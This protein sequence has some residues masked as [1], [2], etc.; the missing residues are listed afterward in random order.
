MTMRKVTA[1]RGAAWINESIA[2]LKNIGMPFWTQALIIGLLG[3]IPYISM[4]QGVLILFFYGSL[5]LCLSN[6]KGQCN[7]FSGF[8]NGNFFR[9][10]PVLLIN[11]AVAIIVMIAIWPD[12]KIAVEA[13]LQGQKLNEEQAI[14]VVLAMFKHMLW[15][16]PLLIVLHWVSLLA[17]PLATIGEQTGADALKQAAA[18]VFSNLPAMIVNLICLFLA[19]LII[20]II[21]IIP[22]AILS[23]AF[24]S[25]P[26]LM[27][28]VTIPFTAIMTAILIALMSANML[29]AYRDIFGDTET[30]TTKDN[31]V[32]I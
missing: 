8:Q 20:T 32:L 15:M 17:V 2:S 29:F 4:L 7:A 14:A 26:M 3:S 19:L 1:G 24:A 21:C 18:A 25:N 31:E 28:L 6:T 30:A 27:Q 9:L 16:M 22:I 23:A 13:G 5:V 12:L 11:I 10:L